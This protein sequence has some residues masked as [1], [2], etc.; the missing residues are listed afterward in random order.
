[1]Q[2]DLA[3]HVP[4]VR[5]AEQPEMRVADRMQRPVDFPVPELDEMIEHRK[6]RREVIIL[7][8]E[9]LQQM[10]MIGQV[11]E[12]LRRRQTVAGKLEFEG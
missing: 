3:L 11:V 6:I 4:P 9:K 5:G 2:D 7:P 1:M 12:D 10:R 8:D